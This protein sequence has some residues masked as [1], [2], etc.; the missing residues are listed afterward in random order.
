M[1]IPTDRLSFEKQGYT[2]EDGEP[3][4]LELP[5]SVREGYV[6]DIIGL[7]KQVS[8]DEG[9][10]ADDAR[11]LVIAALVLVERWNFD[12]QNGDDLPVLKDCDTTEEEARVVQ[13][14]PMEVVNTIVDKA[15]ASEA[16]KSTA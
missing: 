3:L 16:D 9:A 5:R 12:D 14:I 6:Y 8:D 13:E 4:W 2:R 10:S 11:R 15:T 7:N 1:K